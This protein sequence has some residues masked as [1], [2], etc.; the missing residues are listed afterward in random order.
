MKLSRCICGVAV[1]PS[2]QDWYAPQLRHSKAGAPEMIWAHGACL[3]PAMP[4]A[5]ERYRTAHARRIPQRLGYPPINST[6]A[7]CGMMPAE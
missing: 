3:R 6:L 2:A 4:V 5:G 7:L 1:E